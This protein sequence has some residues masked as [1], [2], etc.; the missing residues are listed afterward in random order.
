MD[1]PKKLPP[2]LSRQSRATAGRRLLLTR[3]KNETI[4]IGDNIEVTVIEVLGNKVRLAV[5]APENVPV[6]RTEIRALK[7]KTKGKTT[8]GVERPAP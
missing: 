1:E 8:N 4:I 3:R 6:D 7:L 5:V 2:P